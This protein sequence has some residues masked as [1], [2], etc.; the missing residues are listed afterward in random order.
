MNQTE[1]VNLEEGK[2]PRSN[3][4]PVASVYR[5]LVLITTDGL[6]DFFREWQ[7]SNQQ[8]S[9]QNSKKIRCGASIPYNKEEN[10]IEYTKDSNALNE[11]L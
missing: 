1:L 3:F 2:Q 6:D 5:K 9:I 11:L 7:A 4:L 8:R 10:V